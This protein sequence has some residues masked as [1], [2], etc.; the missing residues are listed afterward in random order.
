MRNRVEITGVN[1]SELKTLSNERM[2]ELIVKS[3][4]GDDAA[5]DELVLGNLKLILSVI[6]KFA[7]RGENLDD[8]FQVGCLGLLKAIDN[9]DMSHG[10]RFSTYAVPMIIGEIRRYLRDNS[11]I[12]VSRSLKDIAYKALHFKEQFLREQH[13]EP[14]AEEIAEELG[15]EPI[16]VI[17]SLEAIQDPIS[18]YTP[19]YN[20]G[21]DEI[22]LIDQI[23]DDENSEERKILELT[24]KDGLKKLSKR[25]RNIINE[26]YY[27][28]KTQM[29]IA[30]EIGIS[31]AQVSRLEKNALKTIFG[32]KD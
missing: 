26:R 12:R 28:G 21:S 6:K 13:R 19:I 32:H 25:E 18:I 11:S 23:K 30:K 20:N 16:D 27:L 8:L 2:M 31:Q 1:T 9:F 22:F 10:V 17:V 14:T 7:H 15:V 5:R 3:Q 4:N 29:E 24:I